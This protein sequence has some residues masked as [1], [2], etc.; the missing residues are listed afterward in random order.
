MIFVF[1]RTGKG[2]YDP[3]DIDP[4]LCT[5]IV[6]GFAILDPNELTIKIHDSWA[7]VDKKFYE[8]VTALKSQGK[9]VTIAIGGWNDSEGDKY[10]RLVSNVAV[11]RNFVRHVVGF[12]KQHNFDGLDLDWE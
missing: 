1:C 3:E 7:D 4:K 11:R 12:I 10:S 5:H 6:Y 8:K 9:K 2:K